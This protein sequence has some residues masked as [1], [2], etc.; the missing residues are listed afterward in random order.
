ML[1]GAAATA[2]RR[3]HGGESGGGFIYVKGPELLNKFVGAS[4]DNVRA[5]FVRAREHKR[6]HGWPAVIFVDEADAILSKR[7]TRLA[8]GD[9]ERTVVPQFLAEMDGL[10]DACALVILAT[11]RPD[12]LDPA[13]VR[14][15]RM[16]VKIQVTRPTREDCTVIATHALAG[17]P[18]DGLSEAQAGE[19]VATEVFAD[20]LTVGAVTIAETG[21]RIDIPLHAIING[22]IIVG[23]VERATELAM[24][25][26]AEAIA[27]A[28]LRSAVVELAR[29]QGA[30]DL[31]DEVRDYV[32]AKA[33]APAPE[34]TRKRVSGTRQ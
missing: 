22:A 34:P 29:E 1:G 31:G 28:D 6:K 21:Q 26:N 30:G 17:K 20:S 18:L 13:V 25:R 2:V 9:M 33:V 14:V 5:L 24:A 12:A 3:L 23:A 16:D 11:N 15:G 32:M 4:E 19:L 27:S 7:G 10:D 8:G